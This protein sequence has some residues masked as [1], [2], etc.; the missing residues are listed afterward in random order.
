M[1]DDVRRWLEE[2]GLGRYAEAFASN[3]LELDLLPDID[4]GDLRD[5]GVVSMGHRKTLLRAIAAL[6]GPPVPA[7]APVATEV[8]TEVAAGAERRQITVLFSDLVGSTALSARLDPEDLREVIRRYQDAVGGAITRWDGHIAKFLGDGVLAYFGWPRANEDQA[9]QAVRAGLEAATLVARLDG[10]GGALAARVGIATGLVVIGDLSGERDAIV[11]ETPNLAARLQELASPGGTV[12]S[13]TTRRMLGTAF[14]LESLGERPLKGF[15]MPLEAWRVRGEGGVQSRFD[16]ARGARLARFVGRTQ[17]RGLLVDRW[18]RARDGEG[19]VAILSGEA[20]MGKSRL[21]AALEA[22]IA[23]DAP[24]T[25][26]LQ[27]SPFHANSAFY[28]IARQLESA[29]GFAPGDDEARKLERLE[30]L[31][32]GDESDLAAVAGMLALPLGPRLEAH[33]TTPQQLKERAIQALLRHLA[34]LA[35]VRPVLLVVEDL[36][37]IDPSTQELLERAVTALAPA[38]VL[39]LLTHRPEYTVPFAGAGNV[40]QLTLAALGRAEVA[41]LVRAVAAIEVDAA[42]VA[43]IVERTDGIPLFVEELTKTLTE[44]DGDMASEVPETLQ[45]SL[46]ARLDRLGEAKEV[47]QV[48]AVIGRGFTL[49]LLARVMEGAVESLAERVA[50]LAA[51]QLVHPLGASEDG[52][53]VFKH[54]LVQDTAYDSLLRGRREQLH[55]RIAMVLEAEFPETVEA[56][57]ELL[58]HHYENAGNAEAALRHLRRAGERAAGT[59]SGAEALAHFERGLVLLAHL[60][61]G[62]ARNRIELALQ[63]GKAWALQLTT[64]PAAVDVGPAY[65]RALSLAKDFKLDA[66]QFAANFGLWRHNW[67]RHGVEHGA[68][69]AQEV[70]RLA[71]LSERRPDEIVAAYVRATD[72]WAS[73]AH[74]AAQQEGA[75]TWTLFQEGAEGTLAY[76]LGHNQGVST[77][78]VRVFGLVGIGEFDDAEALVDQTLAELADADPLTR[79]VISLMLANSLERLEAPRPTL[80]VEAGDLCRRYGFDYWAPLAWTHEGWLRHR[81]G[82][83]PGGLARLRQ[84]VDSWLAAG[85]R[86]YVSNRLAALIGVALDMGIFDVAQDYLAIL[87]DIRRTSGERMILAEGDRLRGE[88]IRRTGGPAEVAAGHFQAALDDALARDALGHAL[89]AAMSLADLHRTGGRIADARAVLTPVVEALRCESACKTDPLWWVMS[90]KN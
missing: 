11:G 60:P 72:H 23:G 73:G 75:R 21:V 30:I 53:Y 84:G 22:E 70:W 55:A 61:T 62:E 69:F 56:E 57:P 4:D 48:G 32:A 47:A 43:R 71:K 90:G 20:G 2:L 18:R 5:L 88:L 54:A 87:D 83:G 78:A 81:D 65:S 12:I 38:A 46:L 33:A 9:E 80:V 36:H 74:G 68:P 89:P 29:A 13:S 63:L 85:Y 76:R 31:L 25:I 52:R 59:S 77:L 28:P 6:V 15:A 42:L 66:E 8:A 14:E 39:M 58:A 44:G 19:Q 35:T 16:A 1:S 3:D 17:E 34:Q 45:A 24:L 50:R 27:A 26:R 7:E 49:G 86:G 64:G 51:A 82:D 37:W 41:E 67:W 10:G 79:T 40:T